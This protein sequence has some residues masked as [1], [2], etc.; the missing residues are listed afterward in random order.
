MANA[1]HNR[2]KF[3]FDGT[4]SGLIKSALGVGVHVGNIIHG[5]F[6][7]EYRRFILINS[8]EGIKLNFIPDRVISQPGN[9]KR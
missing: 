7:G 1:R 3:T 8:P 5:E 4:I 2:N 9:R 6:R